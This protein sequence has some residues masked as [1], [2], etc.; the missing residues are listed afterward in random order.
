MLRKKP[1]LKAMKMKRG[2][3]VKAGDENPLQAY[4]RA[5]GPIMKTRNT[6]RKRTGASR[7]MHLRS[8]RPMHLIPFQGGHAAWDDAAAYR[9]EFE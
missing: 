2:V 4:L 9:G 5:K 6:F 3:N 1:F 7:R 8:R